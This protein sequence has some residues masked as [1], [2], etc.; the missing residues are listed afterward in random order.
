M[1][2][3]SPT[4]R[5]DA[6]ISFDQRFALRKAA[7]VRGHQG[8]RRACSAGQSQARAAFEHFQPDVLEAADLRKTGIHPLG[9]KRVML[10]ARADRVERQGLDIINEEDGVGI[11][12]G[13]GARTLKPAAIGQVD[14]V[15][16]PEGVH[17]SS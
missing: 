9:K 4:H 11:A 7:P 1:V 3:L 14:A 8:R 12:H 5:Q 15:V 6:A 10:N 13:D 16:E 2:V 17:F